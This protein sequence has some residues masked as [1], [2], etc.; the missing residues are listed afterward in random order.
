M[1]CHRSESCSA[2]TA[3]PRDRGAARSDPRHGPRLTRLRNRARRLD[4][5]DRALVGRR[6]EQGRRLRRRARGA[7]RIRR[8]TA[9]RSSLGCRLLRPA[10]RCVRS[11][12]IGYRGV[13]YRRSAVARSRFTVQA[14]RGHTWSLASLR[15]DRSG[16][17]VRTTC[18]VAPANDPLGPIAR[19]TH[20][21]EPTRK[22]SPAILRVL[23]LAHRRSRCV[24][25]ADTPR[26]RSPMLCSGLSSAEPVSHESR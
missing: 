20:D 8:C 19:G 15:R 13:R 16:A 24:L 9:R 3:R 14:V 25:H 23:H 17:G 2:A 7:Q 10:V 11:R 4:R 6:P 21:R 1:M 5:I 18:G 12:W 26:L 22:A